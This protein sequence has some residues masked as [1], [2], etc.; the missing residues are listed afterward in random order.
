MC[1]VVQIRLPVACDLP[2]L[3]QA[4]HSYISYEP[5]FYSKPKQESGPS[6]DLRPSRPASPSR[7]NR[8]S[9]PYLTI[10]GRSRPYTFPTPAAHSHSPRCTVRVRGAGP[11]FVRSPCYIIAEP[12]LPSPG[13]QTLA[14]HSLFRLGFQSCLASK[15]QV[16]AP[17]AWSSLSSK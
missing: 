17:P 14:F 9:S 3:V 4:L 8:S 12:T 6:S 5:P 10:S 2:S 15:P 1:A 13:S 11:A 7:P 16:C